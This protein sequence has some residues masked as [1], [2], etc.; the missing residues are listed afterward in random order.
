MDI[1][2]EKYFIDVLYNDKVV[3]TTYLFDT[4]EKALKWWKEA[5]SAD[6]H[7]KAYLVKEILNH[8]NYSTTY[9]I[10]RELNVN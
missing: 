8:N 10:I 4:E 9:E 1:L 2:S 6:E 3:L 5:G 7:T